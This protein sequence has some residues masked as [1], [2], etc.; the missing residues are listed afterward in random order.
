MI[1]CLN[2]VSVS[3]EIE[4]KTADTLSPEQNKKKSF[5]NRNSVDMNVCLLKENNLHLRKRAKNAKNGI[6][7]KF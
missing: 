1:S 5:L 4:S 7:F 6:V 3:N 2:D